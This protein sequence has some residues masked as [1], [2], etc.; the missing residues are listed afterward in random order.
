MA[1]ESKKPF[2]FKPPRWMVGY[3]DLIANTGGNEV[4]D[5]IERLH[6]EKGLF[7][8][9]HIVYVMASDV[10]G[11]VGLLHRLFNEGLLHDVRPHTLDKE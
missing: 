10:E 9:N 5:L 8:S 2:K 7:Q 4:G 11:Q 1:T 3:F 6:N